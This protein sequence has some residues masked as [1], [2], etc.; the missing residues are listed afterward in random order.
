MNNAAPRTPALTR[1][2]LVKGAAWAV[3]VIAVAAAAPAFACSASTTIGTIVPNSSDLTWDAATRT[4][5]GGY[6]PLSITSSGGTFSGTQPATVSV[7]LA[8]TLPAKFVYDPVTDTYPPR[9]LYGTATFNGLP[10][11]LVATPQFVGSTTTFVC[12]WTA[13]V[14]F[15]TAV[16][17]GA[18]VAGFELSDSAYNVNGVVDHTSTFVATLDFGPGCATA[19]S[20]PVR[21]LYSFA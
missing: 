14:P 10:M 9:P 15:S 5:S 17:A 1:R 13:D 7:R 20:V 12:T 4:F 16:A 8:A 2:T 6:G 18:I 3:P 21:F 11:T 19:A